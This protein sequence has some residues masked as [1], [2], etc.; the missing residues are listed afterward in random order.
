MSTALVKVLVYKKARKHSFFLGVDFFVSLVHYSN[1]T[2][3]C[4]IELHIEGVFRLNQVR[5]QELLS[6]G[7][8]PETIE[9]EIDRL[10]K[11]IMSKG[12]SKGDWE[13]RRHA[14]DITINYCFNELNNK[15]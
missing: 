13:K 3:N 8:E 15:S 12:L 4:T 7:V 11:Y 6:D 5:M 9:R 10:V 1:T 2:R 14:L